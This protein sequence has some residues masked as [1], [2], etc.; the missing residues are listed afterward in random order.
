VFTGPPSGFGFQENPGSAAPVQLLLGAGPNK[1][2]AFRKNAKV[3]IKDY[4]HLLQII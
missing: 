4:L 1:P 2:R 3:T